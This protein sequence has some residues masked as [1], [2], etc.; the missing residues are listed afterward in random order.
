MT[1]KKSA[2]A[3]A[4]GSVPSAVTEGVNALFTMARL[5]ER[6]RPDAEKILG[7]VFAAG[8]DDTKTVHEASAPLEHHE[9]SA[10]RDTVRALPDIANSLG[11]LV[12]ELAGR[13]K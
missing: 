8:Q 10:I 4:P 5:D 6:F 3:S 9:V 2:P 1:A 11:A 13:A 12:A 7:G